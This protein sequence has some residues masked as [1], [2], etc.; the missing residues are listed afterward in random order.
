MPTVAVV[1]VA[2][3]VVVVD[4]DRSAVVTAILIVTPVVH[5]ST[6]TRTIRVHF[7]PN[8]R[9]SCLRHHC[10]AFDCSW[11]WIDHLPSER[12]VTHVLVSAATHQLRSLFP[13][14]PMW[15]GPSQRLSAFLFLPSCVRRCGR[16]VIVAKK[17]PL[18]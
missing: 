1:A 6:A 16:T 7:H 12:Q 9:R 11:G 15:A 2:A 10:A 4:V 17:M 18:D 14:L 8:P 5:P 13:S 3:A